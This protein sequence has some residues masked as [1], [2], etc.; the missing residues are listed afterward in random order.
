MEPLMMRRY[1]LFSGLALML[2]AC[3]ANTASMPTTPG[4]TANASL[5]AQPSTK[6]G[7]YIQHVV[8]VVQ[9]N[10]SFNNLFATFPG[11]DGATSGLNSL[12]QT[13]PLKVTQLHYWKE[14]NNSHKAFK[15]D[16]DGGKMDG[17]DRIFVGRH[18]CPKCAYAYVGPQYIQPYWTLAQ[19]YVLADHMFP[20]ESSGGFS[21]LQ[22]LIRGDSAISGSR[23]LIDFPSHG[24]WGCDAP[25]G[26]TTPVLTDKHQ[27]I[28][29][30]AVPCLK[31]ETLRDT[32]DA[33]GVSWKY[34]TPPLWTGGLPGAYWDAFDAIYA[35]R[36]G[37]EWI[38]NVSS[39]ETNIFG[40]IS[41]SQLAAVS[42]V[43]PN[44]EDSDHSGFSHADRGPTW[45]AEIVNAIGESQYWNTS[46]IIVVWEDWGGWYDNVPPPQLD[47]A[48]LGFR[49]PMIVISPYAKQGYVDHTQYEFGSIVK[50]VEE[51]FKLK[52]LGTTDQRARSLGRAFDFSQ[53]PRQFQQIPTK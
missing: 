36:Y 32:L 9:S 28:K 33:K 27:Y 51:V 13:V 48:G 21:S 14:M 2:A 11:A 20:T 37:P 53:A 5:P 18:A 25:S 30:G 52:S 39:P 43:I 40:D 10:R 12:G 19:Q 29:R 42:W 35:V 23:S 38:S 17:W 46:A 4:S 1:F 45:V 15:T 49:V 8:I 50:F 3:N 41:N 34:Y 22:D 7:D 44:A 26:T 31:Y 6:L 47:Y 16:Y 24:P